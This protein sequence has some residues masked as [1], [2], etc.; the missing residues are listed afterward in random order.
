MID[1]KKQIAHWR[2]SALEDQ[3]VADEL[4]NTGRYRHGLFF[5]QLALEKTL[6]AHIC[7]KT[8]DLAPKIHNLIRLA[9]IADLHLTSHQ[10]DILADINIFN[11]EGRYPDTIMPAL[12]REEVIVY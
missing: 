8:Q 10:I 1:I 6:K 5:L 11:I 7:Q 3:Q 12:T 9:E 2:D 4:I